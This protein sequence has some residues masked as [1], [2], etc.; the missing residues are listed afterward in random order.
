MKVSH[1]DRR[2]WERLTTA[3]Q[4]AQTDRSP[5]PEAAAAIVAEA[6]RDRQARGMPPL[7]DR[8]ENP[9]EAEFYRRAAV[10]GLLLS[11]R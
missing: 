8:F 1:D 7:G 5:S 4:K 9:P 10:L 3:L 11:R 2:R 6:N